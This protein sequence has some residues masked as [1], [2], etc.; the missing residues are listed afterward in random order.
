MRG[1]EPRRHRP[2]SCSLAA[3]ARAN[4]VGQV[5]EQ[6]ARMHRAGVYHGAPYLTNVLMRDGDAPVTMLDLEKSVRFPSDIRGSRM[7]SFDLVNL[8]NSTLAWMGKGYARGGLER[9][10]LDAA[11]IDDTF[12]AVR[13]FRSSKFQRYRR[14]AEYLALGV[15]SRTA[16]R[17]RA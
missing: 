6:V 12:A 14:R 15:L 10:G 17:W 13:A 1:L 4:V 7:A 5:F 2:G 11:A 8:I 3:P 9:Y 16:A